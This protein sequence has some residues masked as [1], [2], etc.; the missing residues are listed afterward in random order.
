MRRAQ[1]LALA[2]LLAVVVTAGTGTTV[3]WI[4]GQAHTAHATEGPPG[5]LGDDNGAREK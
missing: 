4:T 3:S 1:R 2:A 5:T